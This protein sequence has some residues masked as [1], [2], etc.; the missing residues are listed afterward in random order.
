MI[1]QHTFYSLCGLTLEMDAPLPLADRESAFR[2]AP[3]PADITV[4]LEPQEDL[5]QPDAQLLGHGRD[6]TIWR[7]DAQIIRHNQ[8]FF[9]PQAHMTASYALDNWQH[10]SAL[11][12][13][14]DWP[15]RS[16]MRDTGNPVCCDSWSTLSSSCACKASTICCCSGV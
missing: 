1:L 12:R 2:A 13:R 7:Q 9:R 11:V 15:W 16:L 14:E 4:T 6:R 10:V 5:P 8:D 3:A